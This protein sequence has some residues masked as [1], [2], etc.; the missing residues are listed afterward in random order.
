ME[1]N[2]NLKTGNNQSFYSTNWRQEIFAFGSLP[3][4]DVMIDKE[5]LYLI[6][7]P[8]WRSRRNQRK[9]DYSYF[10]FYRIRTFRGLCYWRHT[11]K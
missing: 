3:F 9:F 4:F 8:E 7:M 1:N 5:Y 6:K 10:S 2:P 11:Q